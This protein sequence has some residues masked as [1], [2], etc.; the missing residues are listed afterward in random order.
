VTIVLS[1]LAQLLHIT[2]MLVTAPAA[3][4]LANWL[5]VRLT[6]RTGPPI[7]LP[8]RDLLRLSRK[9]P[10]LSDS[11]SVVSHAA[12]I[13]ALSATLA[14]A[15]LVP[16]FTLGMALSP[17]ADLLVIVSLLTVARVAAA[18]AAFDSGTALPGLLQQSASARAVMAEPALM[19]IMLALALMAGSGNLDLVIGQQRDGVLLP[20]AASALALTALIALLLADLSARDR[21]DMMFGGMQ[22]AMLQTA[23]WL[24]LLIWI[25][26]I[27]GLF[28]PIG[29][30]PAGST[31]LAWLL[32]LVT[33]A[34]K[35]A[36]VILCLSAVRS[37]L[38]QLPRHSLPDLIGVAA[39]LALLATI[40]ILASTAIP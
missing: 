23:G 31:P 9:T 21:S 18:L 5:D 33:W 34:I 8:W 20:A 39:L 25:D 11:S 1:V 38:G 40:M 32:G 22:L 24:R 15:A 10:I 37:L 14:A 12:P 26:L 17:L 29:I 28:L 30:A 3:A 7:L 19:L 13:L 2:L 6:G 27:G 36:A 35:L 16:S 4:G